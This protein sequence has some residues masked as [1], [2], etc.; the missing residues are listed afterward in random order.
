MDTGLKLRVCYIPGKIGVDGLEKGT[1]KLHFF[2]QI[3]KMKIETVVSISAK[4]FQYHDLNKFI[5]W[6]FFF[7]FFFFLQSFLWFVFFK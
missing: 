1:L 5:N 6:F 3:Y 7:F 4:L 2:C